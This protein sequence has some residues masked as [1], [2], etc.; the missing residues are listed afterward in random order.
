MAVDWEAETAHGIAVCY[1]Q[2][3]FPLGMVVYRRGPG[4]KERMVTTAADARDAV[5]G[6]ETGVLG[7]AGTGS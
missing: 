6:R 4:L 2:I 5:A 3:C 7:S 1:A